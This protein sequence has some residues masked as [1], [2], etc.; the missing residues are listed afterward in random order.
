MNSLEV[1]LAEKAE[2]PVVDVEVKVVS[3]TVKGDDFAL[4]VWC[5]PLEQNALIVLDHPLA[6]LFFSITTKLHLKKRWQVRVLL[7]A[8]LSCTIS[9]V[10]VS[11][12]ISPGWETQLHLGPGKV[13]P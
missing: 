5:H 8:F 13:S 9:Q 2:I 7:H 10:R 1:I 11:F 4:G 6:F 3:V 12:L